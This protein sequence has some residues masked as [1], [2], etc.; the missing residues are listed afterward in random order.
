MLCAIGALCPI[1]DSWLLHNRDGCCSP[2]QQ[3]ATFSLGAGVRK[4]AGEELGLSPG[5]A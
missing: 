5:L 4:E 1:G 2:G 3:S